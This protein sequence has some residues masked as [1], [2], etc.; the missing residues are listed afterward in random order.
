MFTLKAIVC[1]GYGSPEVLRVEEV[2]TP[3]P[4]DDEV[5][6]NVYATSVTS[7][8]WRVRSLNMPTGFRLLGRVMFGIWKPRQPILGSELAGVIDAVGTDVTR[9]NEGDTVLAFSDAAMGCHAEDKC[10]SE[11][12]AIAHKP[13]NRTYAEA[14]AL[15]FGG[16]TALQFFQ[17]GDLQPNDNILINGAA[18]SVETA[19]L[20]LAAYVGACVIGV[21]STAHLDVVKRIGADDAIDYTEDDVT[22]RVDAYDLLLDTAGTIPVSQGTN[23][24]TAGGRL[25]LV[26]GSLPNMLRIPWVSLTSNKKVLAGPAEGRSEDVQFLTDLAEA[27]RYKPVIDPSY[28]FEE[29]AGAHAYVGAGHKTGNVVVTRKPARETSRVDT[30]PGTSTL[31]IMD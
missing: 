29:I 2:G 25:L 7:G 23:M 30:Y 27:G 20:Q 26:H 22:E 9:F 11:D 21:G 10:M 13:E 3:T 15:S 4:E 5:L 31:S 24:L 18:G 12:G 16:T 8:D 28:P 19:A 17:R 6:I 14:A 1:T